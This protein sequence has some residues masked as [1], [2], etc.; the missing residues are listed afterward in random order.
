MGIQVVGRGLDKKAVRAIQENVIEL[1]PVKLVSRHSGE[2]IQIAE[3]TT[4][5]ELGLDVLE[6]QIERSGV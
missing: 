4:P 3:S 1:L 6:E 5:T 2:N